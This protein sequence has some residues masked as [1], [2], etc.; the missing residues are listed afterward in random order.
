MLFTF[1]A[2]LLALE[3]AL[4]L[5][6]LEHFDGVLVARTPQ[7]VVPQELQRPRPILG[8]DHG[9]AKRPARRIAHRS[10]GVHGEAIAHR[11]PRIEK[12]VAD[13]L[14]PLRPAL[15]RGA[16]RRR[17]GVQEQVARYS[18][19]SFSAPPGR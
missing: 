6:Q 7:R 3:I 10:I 19:I 4:A 1:M 5:R 12:R 14:E 16:R 15:V 2:V 13:A 11:R 17:P 9:V 8:L 18:L